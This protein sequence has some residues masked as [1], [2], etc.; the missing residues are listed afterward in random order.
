MIGLPGT[1]AAER[2]GEVVGHVGSS[3]AAFSGRLVVLCFCWVGVESM[4]VLCDEARI[5]REKEAFR[6]RCAKWFYV[7]MLMDLD[8]H[9]EAPNPAGSPLVMPSNPPTRRRERTHGASLTNAPGL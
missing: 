9:A 6:D 2:E 3:L 4:Y 1:W 7:R 5:K 8:W